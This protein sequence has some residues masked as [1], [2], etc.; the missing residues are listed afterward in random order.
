[1]QASLFLVNSF[2]R[3]FCPVRNL[4]E[5]MLPEE[6]KQL[7]LTKRSWLITKVAQA[8]VA[9]RY[10]L[11]NCKGVVIGG[12]FSQRYVFG[13]TMLDSGKKSHKQGVHENYNQKLL[14]RY[15][16]NFSS[17]LRHGPSIFLLKREGG[18]LSLNAL[19]IDKWNFA[20]YLQF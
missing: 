2:R 14:C 17:E 16:M 5:T 3:F 19:D 8:S 4:T 7:C 12:S 18:S 9:R 20:R 10:K 15:K 1:M 13:E 6:T 11:R